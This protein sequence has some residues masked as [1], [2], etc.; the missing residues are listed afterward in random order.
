MNNQIWATWLSA[1]GTIGATSLALLQLAYSTHRNRL[2]Q[3]QTQARKLSAWYI[4]LSGNE[5]IIVSNKSGFPVYD[6]VVTFTINDGDGRGAPTEL[7]SNYQHALHVLPPGN[8]QFP[9]PE[10]WCGCGAFPG[11]ELAFPD[12]GGWNWLRTSRGELKSLGKV[13]P[14]QYYEIWYP[15]GSSQLK[16]VSLP[17]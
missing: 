7:E 4:E 13:N 6:A 5:R 11:V 12:A 17:E 9:V 3:K 15:Y 1:I 14:I 16:P 10:G 2:E 8:W